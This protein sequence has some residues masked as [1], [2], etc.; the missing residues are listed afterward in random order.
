MPPWAVGLCSHALNHGTTVPPKTW[1][2]HVP[3]PGFTEVIK[4]Q[5]LGTQGQRQTNKISH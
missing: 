5:E 1:C 3:E 2:I 4:Y